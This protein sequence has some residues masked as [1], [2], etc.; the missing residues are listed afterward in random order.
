M[1][2]VFPKIKKPRKKDYICPKCYS[3]NRSRLIAI[4][5]GPDGR[6]FAFKCGWD[7]RQW[8]V[9]SKLIINEIF[10]DQVKRFSEMTQKSGKEVGGLLIRTKA[11]IVVMDME[12]MGE[13]R[14]VS[15]EKTRKLQPGEEILGTWHSHPVSDQPSYWDIASFLRD[16][17]EQI[18]CVSG[19]EGTLT[20]MVKTDGTTKLPGEEVGRW[21]EENREAKTPLEEIGRKH[22]FLVYKGLPN[23]LRLVS[24]DESST[25]LE[26][27]VRGVKGVK[28]L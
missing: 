6:I 17:W 28:R 3:S 21:E 16:K 22:G 14:Q 2:P 7:D 8:F 12:Q 15:M 9:A 5:D 26:K 27:L 4:S 11:G 20:V 10:Q 13:E 24:G 19:V 25:T 1:Y 23:K 18:S